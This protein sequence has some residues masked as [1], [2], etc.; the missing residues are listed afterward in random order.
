M[1]NIVKVEYDV[2]NPWILVFTDNGR[3]YYRP[4][5][6]RKNALLRRFVLKLLLWSVQ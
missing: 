1:A 3:H 2:A 6:S 5:H 4:L